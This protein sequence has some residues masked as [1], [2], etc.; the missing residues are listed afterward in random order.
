[1]GKF[2]HES[3][4]VVSSQI[5]DI[6]V[7]RN[8]TIVD[9]KID[10]GCSIGDDTN[11][12]RCV[13]G[14]NVVINRRSYINDS[15]IGAYTYMGINTTMNF[16]KIG[17]FCSLARNVD[18]GGFDHD[19]HKVTTMPAF[20]YAQ[21]KNGGGKLESRTEHK[22]F[23]K[24]GND[25]WIAAGAQV[26]HK[27]T[28]G[29]G[30]VVGGGAVVTKDVP[31]EFNRNVLEV[32][33]QPLEDGEVSISRL[34]GIYRFP[35]DF[36][37]VAARNPC[38]CGQYPDMNRCTCTVRQIRNYN[39]RISKPLLDRID[40]NV[41]VR[42]VDCRQLFGGRTGKN[43]A[44]MRESVLRTQRIQSER[45]SGENI[46]FNSQMDS[47]LCSKYVVLDGEAKNFMEDCFADMDMTARGAYRVL[48]IARTIADLD[49]DP[50]V[51]IK[52]LREA[53]FFRNA[54]IQGGV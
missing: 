20:R 33:R 31:P 23:C 1:M 37:L 16:T 11:V 53:V 18:V 28:I 12:E 48:K 5:G 21:T 6:K 38:P 43:S 9:S 50:E 29:D 52:H 22:D 35:A 42:K 15:D 27:V 7:F 17:K 36:M 24:I 49:G 39:A 32:M 47:A 13:I 4:R 10:S 30:A 34:G 51:G 26:L 14:N 19:Y 25:V 45:F 46:R 40:I 44:E 41:D 3:A 8:A 54:D 2:I